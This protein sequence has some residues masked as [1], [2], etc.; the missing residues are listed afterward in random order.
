MEKGDNKKAEKI[1]K[2]LLKKIP[3]YGPANYAISK[4][5]ISQT[6]YDDA[7]FYVKNLEIDYPED[8]D[9]AGLRKVMP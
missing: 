9:V 7:E 6:K 2:K 3:K 5:L 8:Q 1:L 4:C